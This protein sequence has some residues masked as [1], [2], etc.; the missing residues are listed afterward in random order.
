MKPVD[1]IEVRV[2]HE[3]SALARGQAA[4][5]RVQDQVGL[6]GVHVEHLDGSELLRE[7]RD[8]RTALLRVAEEAEF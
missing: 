6:P 5:E 8:T 7:R 2:D 3:L 1:T 4:G